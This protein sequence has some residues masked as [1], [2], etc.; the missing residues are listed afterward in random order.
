MV[1]CGTGERLVTLMR[2]DDFRRMALALDGAFEAAH[3]ARHSGRVEAAAKG[4]VDVAR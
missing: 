3:A 1:V 2:A 4:G